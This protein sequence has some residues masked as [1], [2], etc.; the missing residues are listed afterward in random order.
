MC[1]QVRKARNGIMHT[2][3]MKLS[4]AD[5]QDYSQSMIDLLNDP[6]ISCFH[7]AQLALKD[8]HSVC[9]ITKQALKF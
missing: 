9:I 4:N 2:A 8:I 3:D 1:F 5:L 6:G 7:T